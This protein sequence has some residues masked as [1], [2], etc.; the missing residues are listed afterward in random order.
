MATC[1]S[2]MRDAN[3]FSGWLEAL[4]TGFSMYLKFTGRWETD[5]VAALRAPYKARRILLSSCILRVVLHMLS[6]EKSASVRSSLKQKT[7]S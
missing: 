6:K 2:G 7:V 3:R 5:V 1:W 4:S